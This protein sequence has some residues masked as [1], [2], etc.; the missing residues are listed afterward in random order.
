M[1]VRL[2]RN[3]YPGSSAYLHSLWQRQRGWVDYHARHIAHLAD[4]LS[5]QLEALGDVARVEEAVQIRRLDETTLVPRA[6]VLIHDTEPS[7]DLAL[8]AS[9]PRTLPS[10]AWLAEALERVK[11]MA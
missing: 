10:I 11:A 3:Q 4:A 9:A 1:V 5:A 2:I 6:D 8:A 7:R